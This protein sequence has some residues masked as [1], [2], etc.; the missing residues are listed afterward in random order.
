[1]PGMD[2]LALLREI[3]ERWPD[4]PVMMVTAYGDEENRLL[5][6]E[7]PPAAPLRTGQYLG[8][9]HRTEEFRPIPV[10]PAAGDHLEPRSRQRRSPA[11]RRRGTRRHRFR[12]L[13]HRT[14]WTTERYNNRARSAEATAS[15]RTPFRDPVWYWIDSPARHLRVRSLALSGRAYMCGEPTRLTPLRSS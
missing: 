12:L 10:P 11:P 4:L 5:L 8:T 2:G 9:C 6:L 7:A 3:K 14:G 15:C 13:G 1:M